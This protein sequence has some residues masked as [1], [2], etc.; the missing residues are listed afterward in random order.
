MVTPSTVKNL[1]LI[2]YTWKQKHYTVLDIKIHGNVNGF[3][4]PLWED[5]YQGKD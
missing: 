4:H 5:N 2:F 3:E 1:G